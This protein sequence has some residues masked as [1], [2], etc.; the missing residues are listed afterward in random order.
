MVFDQDPRDERES[1]PCSCGGEIS[2]VTDDHT[3]WA[4][5]KCNFLQK[6]QA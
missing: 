2:Q 4:C 6:E 1:Y 5:N 3:W